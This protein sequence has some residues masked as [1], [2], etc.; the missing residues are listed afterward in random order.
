MVVTKSRLSHGCRYQI[1]MRR[2]KNEK[3]TLGVSVLTN[4]IY[5][6]TVDTKKNIWVGEKKDMTDDAIK[7]VFEWFMRHME[8]NE[9]YSITF[10][11]CEYVLKMQRK[12]VEE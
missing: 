4:T 2:W 7:A 5:Y 9:E 11:D 3:N 6:G 1:S 8:G 12:K 10:N